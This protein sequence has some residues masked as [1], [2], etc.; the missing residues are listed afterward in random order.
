[1]PTEKTAFP[2]A[3]QA[4]LLLLAGFVLQY[5]LGAALYDFRHALGITREQLLALAMLLANGILITAAMH[6]GG[7]NYREVVHPSESSP[8]SIFVFL[9][10]PVL[11]LIPLGV[12]LNVSL[13][14]A[15]EYV[16]PVSAWE[17]QAFARMVEPTLPAFIATCL[18]APVV[19]EMLFRGILLRSFLARYPRGLAIGYSALYFGAAHLNI[20]Q[21]S[22]AFLM[23][24]LMGWLYERSRSLI[25]CVALHAAFNSTVFLWVAPKEA[26]TG[27]ALSAIP[28]PVWL[29]ALI[30]AAI[31][32]LVLRR[33]LGSTP[34]YTGGMSS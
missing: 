23:G 27:L 6:M 34:R 1:M 14:S 30:A 8:L 18:I 12:L 22:V 28:T 26:E 11:L 32:A 33:L 17:Q 24:L 25:P 15:I 4:A 20:Y 19:E 21:F 2:S 7:V 5:I 9:V 16:L 29:A 3:R 31:A 10:P 13:S